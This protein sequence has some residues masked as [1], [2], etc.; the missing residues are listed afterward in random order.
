MVLRSLRCLPAQKK[1]RLHLRA[2]R[3]TT[4]WPWGNFM[5]KLLQA[6]RVVQT[7]RH[8]GIKARSGP[9]GHWGQTCAL[10]V[11]AYLRLISS[12][13]AATSAHIFSR[14]AAIPAARAGSLR[15]R[16]CAASHA[17]L[18][19]PALSRATVATGK[20]GRHLHG[21]EKSVHACQGRAPNGDADD[22]AHGAGGYGPGQMRGHAAA[23]IKTCAPSAS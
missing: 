20:P 5:L 13:A 8:L 17:A 2:G 12:P 21:G 11:Q 22:R 15:A 10:R 19:A 7:W 23:Q 6:H 14:A 4:L 3:D 18:R 1:L 16:I 9:T